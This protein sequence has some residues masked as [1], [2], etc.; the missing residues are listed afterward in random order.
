MKTR[1]TRTVDRKKEYT[2]EVKN[3][4][5]KAVRRG[6]NL[7]RNEAVDSILR[8]SKSGIVYELYSPQ[9]R[10]HQASAPG[11]APASD[12]GRLASNIFTALD[13]DGLG[14]SIESRAEYSAAL[15][16]GH[17]YADGITLQARPFMVP[18]LESQRKKIR[19]LIREA[20]K[21]AN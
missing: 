19:N 2:K 21:G 16:F 7:V 18:A 8:G 20:V 1:V 15:E 3:R 5:K 10:T 13:R 4:V 11:E 14:G 9:R 17:R 6:C 12:T